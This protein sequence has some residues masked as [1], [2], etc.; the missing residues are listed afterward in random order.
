[1]GTTG[2]L[3]ARRRNA[4]TL[5]EGKDFSSEAPLGLVLDQVQ[6]V[7]LGGVRTQWQLQ[8]TGRRLKWGLEK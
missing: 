5:A 3:G 1:M 2:Y 6:S 7:R 4:E 8:Q